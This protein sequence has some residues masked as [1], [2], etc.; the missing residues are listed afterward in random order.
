MRDL[1]LSCCGLALCLVGMESTAAEEDTAPVKVTGETLRV[2][3]EPDS[4]PESALARR[5]VM[6]N[7]KLEVFRDQA[8]AWD[9]GAYLDKATLRDATSERQLTVGRTKES[10]ITI[11]HSRPHLRVG[12]PADVVL[13]VTDPQALEPG[14]YR[15]D[16]MA[17][18][19]S[20][21]IGVE[22]EYHWPLEVIVRGRRITS[23]RFSEADATAKTLR[24]GGP[25][26][27][28]I[29]L[30]TTDCDLAT[31][32]L[33]LYATG[34]AKPER[35]LWM[36]L[37]VAEDSP[38]DPLLDARLKG[39]ITSRWRDGVLLAPAD[40]SRINAQQQRHTLLATLP[41]SFAMGPLE[42]RVRWQRLT[43]EKAEPSWIDAAPTSVLVTAGL[44]A[45]PRLALSGEAVRIE[46]W[47]QNDL[48][49]EATATVSAA[50]SPPASVKL[51]RLQASGATRSAKTFGYAGYAEPKAY[52][53]HQVAL[54]STGN[55][56]SAAE[57]TTSFSVVYG[58][59]S[60]LGKS[61][62]IVVFVGNSPFWWKWQGRDASRRVQQAAA[63]RLIDGTRSL[64][65]VRV[66]QRG[67]FRWTGD[68][69]AEL[70]AQRDPQLAFFSGDTSADTAGVWRVP[71]RQSLDLGLRVQLPT[72][73]AS[74]PPE[75]TGDRL[76]AAR[77][78]ISG[79]DRNDQ[80]VHRVVHVPIYLRV[81]SEAH[82]YRLPGIALGLA[83]LLI[84]AV[85]LV[86]RRN[87][88]SGAEATS[89]STGQPVRKSVLLEAADED[90]LLSRS[91]SPAAARSG[92]NQGG[93][94]P[95]AAR[96]A[97]AEEEDED[98]LSRPTRPRGAPSPQ[99]AAAAP[100]DPTARRS[101]DD[102][103][104][105]SLLRR[106]DN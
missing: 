86:A 104:D 27:L 93:A 31:G 23:V 30:E 51:K 15:G 79:R 46:A 73:T 106:S 34:G 33:E 48:G 71:D 103:D 90:N 78:L 62:P 57:M 91:A 20:P 26:S 18:M 88:S 87:R 85:V 43:A 54:K 67:L 1:M 75:P 41:E 81:A 28:A 14:F 19:S 92:P 55:S 29:E 65:D 47:T 70:D 13:R 96:A 59:T 32:E 63:L 102:S 95:A 7:E 38:I 8:I 60:T 16:L 83:L 105:L 35:L 74:S 58:Q 21:N 11:E 56:L 76:Y 94:S 50:G 4:T 69:G 36:P 10:P 40:S 72:R 100:E 17:R 101:D 6:V 64:S 25:A 39:R 80:P 99:Q 42:A 44:L 24:I 66:S 52:G 37:P 84:V 45:A 89:D 9:P 12:E 68:L 82:Y 22:L 49:A 98:L 61:N 5:R 3:V 77:F 2:V 97:E 53:P